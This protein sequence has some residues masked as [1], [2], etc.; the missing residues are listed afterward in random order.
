MQFDRKPVCSWHGLESLNTRLLTCSMMNQ[1]AVEPE[2]VVTRLG[3][4]WV[5]QLRAPTST[6]TSMFGPRSSSQTLHDLAVGPN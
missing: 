4:I 5:K 3:E 6:G 2:A 1:T